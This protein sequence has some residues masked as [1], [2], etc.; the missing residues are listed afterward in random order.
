MLTYDEGIDRGGSKTAETIE[1]QPSAAPIVG[2]TRAQWAA[3]KAN[4]ERRRDEE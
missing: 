1:A 4:R 2:L 3:K